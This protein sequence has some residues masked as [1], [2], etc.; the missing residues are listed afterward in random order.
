MN[1]L[2]HTL[3][4]KGTEYNLSFTGQ[5]VL[6]NSVMGL[7]GVRR[8]LL[9]LERT[10]A[11]AFNTAIIDLN[12]VKSCSIK[13]EYG[14]IKGG[15]LNIKKLE[16]YLE[17]ISLQFAFHHKA[18]VEVVFYH[19]LRNRINEAAERE[20]KARH[21]VAMLSKMLVPERKIA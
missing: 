8:K 20:S 17:K 18:P 19:C 5:E 15:A 3:C 13:K 4:N 1:E 16:Q 12:D 6:G 2:L 14:T 11:K 7:D 21:W 9:V 10:A